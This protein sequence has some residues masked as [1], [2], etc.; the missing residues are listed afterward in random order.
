MPTIADVPGPYRFFFYS[1]DCN[2]RPHVH[3]RRDQCTC[4]FWLDRIEPARNAGFTLRE[5]ARIRGTIFQY[6]MTILE[7]W[8]EHC[9]SPGQ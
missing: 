7:A 2:E 6:R 3:V 5:L 8:H 1:F 4:K 9:S